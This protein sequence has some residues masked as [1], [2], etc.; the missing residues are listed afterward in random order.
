M[1]LYVNRKSEMVYKSSPTLLLIKYVINTKPGPGHRHDR[2]ADVAGGGSRG[3]LG[4]GSGLTPPA[5][6]A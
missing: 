2:G 4:K 1:L 3:H 6:T 5:S